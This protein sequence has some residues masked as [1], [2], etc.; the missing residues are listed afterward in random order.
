M[1]LN[2]LDWW[3]I[4]LIKDGNGQYLFGNPASDSYTA[5]WG[6]PCAVTN[7]IP[8]G[9]FLVGGFAT[10]AALYIRM[11][12]VIEVS[13]SHSDYF[14]RNKLAIR[15]EERLLLATYTPDAF[16]TGSFVQSPA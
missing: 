3:K 14:V 9:T 16:V 8:Q 15:C 6:V 1:V 5:L 4:R 2:P 12:G 7:A 10:G 13:D 11:D